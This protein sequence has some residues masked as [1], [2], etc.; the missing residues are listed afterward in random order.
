MSVIVIGA[1]PP[2]LELADSTVLA[3][4]A[5][6]HFDTAT[7]TWTVS[8][9]HGTTATAR[10]VVDARL[11]DFAAVARHG[12]PNHFRI[13]G[14][15]IRRQARYVSRCL[16]LVERSGAARIEAKATIVLRRWRPQ[17]VEPCFYL[18]GSQ[19]ESDDLY[20][21]PAT[22][23]VDGQS[24]ASR[25]RLIGHLDAIDGRYHWQGTVFENLPDAG[26]GRSPGLTLTIADRTA[27]A[28]V[29]EQTPWGT[30]MISGVGDPPFA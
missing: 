1:V 12:T 25:V 16:R 23:T 10:I 24:I 22:V 3:D 11:S 14:P 13:P 18:T 5:A 30:H 17:P 9:S 21:G 7:E 28:R 26:R 4:K 27:A 20:D 6:A 8:D 19:P 2:G 29:V 15:D